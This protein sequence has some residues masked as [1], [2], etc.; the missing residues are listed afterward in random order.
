MKTFIKKNEVL[1]RIKE[2]YNIDKDADLATFLGISR[3]TLSNWGNRNSIDYDLV[4]SKCEQVNLD[5]LLT[6]RGSMLI[7]EES[8]L[9]SNLINAQSITPP[10][11]SIVMRLMDKLDERERKI[12]ELTEKL[13]AAEK[14]LI[15]VEAKIE[16]LSKPN[17]NTPESEDCPP[18]LVDPFTSV[19]YG[20]YIEP[21]KLPVKQKSSKKSSGL[22]T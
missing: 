4:F 9:G 13:C 10:D 17:E 8:N 20:D 2:A 12:E 7:S 6:G 21:S 19:S 16:A 15:R 5:W 1:E 11:P 22:K 3:S 14:E 18:L